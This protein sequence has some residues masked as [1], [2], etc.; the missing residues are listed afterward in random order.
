MLYRYYV[1][2]WFG[3]GAGPDEWTYNANSLSELRVI[4][5]KEFPD[6]NCGRKTHL[7]FRD[8]KR[9]ET[10]ACC[11]TYNNGKTFIIQGESITKIGDR[12]IKFAARTTVAKA[13]EA[14]LS[15]QMD[16]LNRI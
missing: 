2:I 14:Q 10:Y 5:N 15:K 16:K 13:T 4:L 8:S 12:F 3:S 11:T 9:E 7:E 1:K 6:G